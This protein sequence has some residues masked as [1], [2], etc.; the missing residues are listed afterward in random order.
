M[1][2]AGGKNGNLNFDCGSLAKGL[3]KI[4]LAQV[5]KGGVGARKSMDN[6]QR[7]PMKNASNI[8]IL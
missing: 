8:Y 1:F 7:I 3:T 5:I 6:Q 2:V 4:F